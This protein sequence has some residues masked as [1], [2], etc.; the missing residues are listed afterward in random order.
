VNGQ[1]IGSRM[2]G[3]TVCGGQPAASHGALLVADGC[4]GWPGCTVLLA[5]SRSSWA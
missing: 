2:A 1:A 3:M 4:H 5:W